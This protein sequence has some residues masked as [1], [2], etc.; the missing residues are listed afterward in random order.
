M[1][2]T[3]VFGAGIGFALPEVDPSPFALGLEV[4]AL[5]VEALEV[6]VLEVAL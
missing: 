6:E 5:D 2:E 1:G 4:E 3:N